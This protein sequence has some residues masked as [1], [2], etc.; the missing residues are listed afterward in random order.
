MP[1]DALAAVHDVL[2][3][4]AP[5]TGHLTV[6]EAHLLASVA[7]R[8][9]GDQ[10]AAFAAVESA[11][12]LAEADRLVLPFAMTGSLELLGAMPRQPLPVGIA[13]QL[14]VS[15]NTVNTHIRN[16]DAKLQTQDR[17][18]PCTGPGR[19][20]CCRPGPADGLLMAF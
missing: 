3:G 10:R 5:A 16:I 4:K 14:S 18:A 1:A 17:S 9:P 20:G 2:T 19:G 15:V 7:D 11:L 13:G 12:D 8:E 6:A